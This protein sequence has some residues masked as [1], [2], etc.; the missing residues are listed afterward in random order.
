[1]YIFHSRTT[2]VVDKCVDMMHIEIEQWKV[3]KGG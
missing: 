1:M 3:Q 2:Y